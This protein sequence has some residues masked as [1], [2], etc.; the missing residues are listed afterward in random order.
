MPLKIALLIELFYP[1]VAGCENR[2]FEIGRRLVKHGHEVHVFTLQ[3]EADLPKEETV[4]GIIVHRYA[5]SGN[6]ITP[7]GFRSVNGVLKYALGTL[8]RLLTENFDI[9]YSNQWPMMHSVFARPTA[10]PLLQEWCEVWTRSQRMM[11]LQKILSLMS[12]HHVAVS[13]FT[14]RRVV[15][16]LKVAPEKVS[17]IPN[18]VNCRKISDGSNHKTRGRIVYVGR[19]VPHKHV[20]MLVDAFRQV[21]KKSP[22][23]ELHVIGSGPSLAMIK[24]QA[25]GLD[26]FF[27]HGFLPENQMLDILRSSSLLIFPSEREGSGIVA[28]EAMAAGTPVITVDFPDNAAKELVNG[29]NGLVVPPSTDAM[30]QATLTLF[31]DESRLCEMS[32]YAQAFARQYDWDSIVVDFEE[33]LKNVVEQSQN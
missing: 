22:K 27:I 33:V 10:S 31:D 20:E 15:N 30:A 12:A 28:L 4:D 3:Y 11:M 24:D 18:G 17:V 2:F 5:L 13:E 21:K 25:S 9:Y 14:R 26:D 23:A 32:E 8:A 7:T 16:F 19:L 1:H 29:M 6:Y